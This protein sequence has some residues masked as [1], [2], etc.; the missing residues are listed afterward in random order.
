[1][2]RIY[3]ICRKI[4]L[5]IETWC[6]YKIRS[7]CKK[8]YYPFIFNA[9]E[10]EYIT[11]PIIRG[12]LKINNYGR[13]V[14]GTNLVFNSSFVSNPMGLSKQCTI[15]VSKTGYLSIDNGSGFSGV[16]IYCSNKIIIGKNLFCGGNVSIWDTDFH[17]LNY[18]LR[19]EHDENSIISLP[20]EIGNDVFIGANSIILKGVIIG[21][22]SIIGAGSVVTKKIPAYEIWAGNPAKFIKKI[23]D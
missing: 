2:K 18:K 3:K 17:S 9:Q 19:R 11:I 22:K 14:L 23:I 20:I 16:S 12:K 1:M 15:Y 13:C 21:D 5:D 4:Y 10:I 6:T 8:I 7:L